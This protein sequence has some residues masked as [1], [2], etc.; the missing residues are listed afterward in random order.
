M[1]KR[2]LLG[3]DIGG[4]KCAVT[5]GESENDGITIR[6]KEDFETTGVNET[7][8]GIKAAIWEVL[9]RNAVSNKEID[10]IGVSCG[11]PLDS[12]AGVIM[13]PPTCPVG[14]TFRLSV[15]LPGS[16]A[17]L[18]PCTTTPMPARWPSGHSVRAK[19]RGTWCSSLSAPVW[20]PD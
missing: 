1:D 11:G 18:W 13:S 5:L 14:T 7:I 15:C 17:F 9:K 4:T 2:L 20:E 12:K 6:D 10:A 8:A 3:V 19:V 16:S